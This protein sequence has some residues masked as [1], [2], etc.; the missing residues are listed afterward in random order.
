MEVEKRA[1]LTAGYVTSP[2]DSYFRGV[3]CNHAFRD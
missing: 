3:N 2:Y 1:M